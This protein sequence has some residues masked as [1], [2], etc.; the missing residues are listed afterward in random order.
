[1]AGEIEEPFR[2]NF[3]ADSFH[4]GS[5]SFGR[6]ETE[7]LC[8]EKRS[9]FSHNRYL[10]EVDKFSKL[11]SVSEKKAYFEAHFRKKGIPGQGSPVCPDETEYQTSENDIS[12]KSDEVGHADVEDHFEPLIYEPQIETLVDDNDE[13]ECISE[14]VEVEEEG[15]HAKHGDLLYLNSMPGTESKENFDGEVAD[16]DKSHLS[17]IT[18]GLLPE[19][20]FTEECSTTSPKHEE[21]SSHK[22]MQETKEDENL[23]PRLTPHVSVARSRGHISSKEFKGLEKK[24]GKQV[25]NVRLR[26]KVEA[27]TSEAPAQNNSEVHK[28]SRDKPGSRRKGVNGIKSGEKESRNRTLVEQ[29]ANR[30]KPA[31][32]GATKPGAKPDNSRFNL[33]TDERAQRRKQFYM[34]LEEKMRA[35]EAEKHQIHAKTREKTDAELK[36]LR[37]SLNFK[38]K[39]MPSFYRGALRE[40]DGNKLPQKATASNIKPRKLR[41]NCSS[42]SSRF[43]SIAPLKL[44]E[45]TEIAIFIDKTSKTTDSP[46]VS[47]TISCHSTVTSDSI[48]SSPSAETSNSGINSFKNGM[49]EKDEK[50]HMNLRK[51]KVPEG[52]NLCKGKTMDVNQKSRTGKRTTYSAFKSGRVAT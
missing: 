26:S 32:I 47:G 15:N 52:N 4:C 33:I 2:L 51:H 22:G 5:I 35:K 45:E 12:E 25:N 20:R 39:P 43:S 36:Q 17:D 7:D 48:P 27:I 18:V 24:T 38:A 42:T 8:W 19:N 30:V 34:N 28:T 11:R 40:S 16:S 49:K 3:Q 14:Q 1:M 31:T 37:K 6:F 41:T 10:E 21:Y 23:K 13:A 44:E 50:K 46:H 9:S 29:S